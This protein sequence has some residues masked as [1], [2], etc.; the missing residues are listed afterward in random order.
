VSALRVI[1]H[2]F[3]PLHA[4]PLHPVKTAPKAELLVTESETLPV[5]EAL[6][7]V[8]VVSQL[9]PA[10]VDVIVPPIAEDFVTVSV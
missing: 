5:N 1:E 4:P 7:V 9:I 6:C 2:V 10:G 8:Q 3:T